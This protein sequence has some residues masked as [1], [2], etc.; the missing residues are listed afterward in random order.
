M[1]ELNVT[2]QEITIEDISDIFLVSGTREVYEVHFTFT[3]EWNEY[4]KTAVFMT[5][6]GKPIEMVLVD[7]NTCKMPSEVIRR[8]AHVHIGVYGTNGTKRYPTV[9]TDAID[10]ERG[11]DCGIAHKDPTADV[12]D[13]L[14]TALNSKASKTDVENFSNDLSAEISRATTAETKNAENISTNK[15]NIAIEVNRAVAV[16]ADLLNKI[17]AEENSRKKADSQL[18]NKYQAI[19]ESVATR[20]DANETAIST[21]VSDREYKDS[22][23]ETSVNN[24]ISARKEAD[25][26]LTDLVVT[27]KNE[28]QSAVNNLQTAINTEASTRGS[29]ISQLTSK[30]N[31]LTTRLNTLAD[32][33]DTTLD[34]MSEIVA[35]IKNNKSLI[36]GITTDKVSTADI[37]TVA[38]VK[39]YL[40]I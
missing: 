11:V 3:D 25:V 13:Q 4:G 40:G 27:E 7:D 32:S 2:S 26:S 23:I 31:A 28:R 30:L 9:W 21:E 34:Q 15:D 16:E 24:E 38:E 20:L 36:D 10:I 1:I 19:A 6:N 18:D 37:A 29:E 14:L 35:Y 5:G 17:S 22:L 12:Y 8:G 39:A 33:D